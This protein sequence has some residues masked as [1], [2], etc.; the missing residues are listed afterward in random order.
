MFV[1]IWS[2]VDICHVDICLVDLCLRVSFPLSFFMR[3]RGTQGY[4]SRFDQGGLCPECVSFFPVLIADLA[5]QH[6]YKCLHCRC[7][8][9]G[10]R[11][12]T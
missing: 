10:E 6:K 4:N 3:E 8:K 9:V 2:N 5:D 7:L 12:P 1:F 11:S